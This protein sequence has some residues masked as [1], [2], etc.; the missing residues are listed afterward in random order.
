MAIKILLDT[1]AYSAYLNKNES[2][3]EIVNRA[4]E[5]LFSPVVLGE[6]EYGFKKGNKYKTNTDLLDYFLNYPSVKIVHVSR[7]TANVFAN[8][9]L[10]LENKGKPIPTNDMWI[11]AQAIEHNALLVTF[12]D[13]F[14]NIETLQK[15]KPI[16]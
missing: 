6:L 12:D 11:A 9:K 2:V 10:Q 13:H 14:T 4:D 15:W 16:K 5:I 7:A 8:I 1:N 3:Y